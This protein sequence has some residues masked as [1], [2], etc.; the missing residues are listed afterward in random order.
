MIGPDKTVQ[1][2][3]RRCWKARRKFDVEAT[4]SGKEEFDE[5]EIEEENFDE[6][7]IEGIGSMTND[8]SLMIKELSLMR[9][10]RWKN[11]RW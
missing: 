6:D 8:L 7:E 5:E 3:G 11:L 10:P 1:A 4:N 2:L 9:D